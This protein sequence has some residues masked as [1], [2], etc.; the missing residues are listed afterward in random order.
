M[1]LMECATKTSQLE[2]TLVAPAQ[3]LRCTSMLAAISGAVR[4]VLWHASLRSFGF[5]IGT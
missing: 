2:G 1:V 3:Q 4:F 5:C